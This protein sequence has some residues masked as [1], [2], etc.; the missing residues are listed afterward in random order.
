[1]QQNLDFHT[2]TS[3][4]SQETSEERLR[5][6]NEAIETIKEKYS[7]N[8]NNNERIQNEVEKPKQEK[9]IKEFKLE[10]EKSS[11]KSLK[12]FIFIGLIIFISLIST[13]VY[14]NNF[15]VKKEYSKDGSIID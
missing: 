3:E 11:K 2:K 12:P 13:I 7:T 15:G 5:R 8:H 1:M 9:K 14:K 4:D 6:I 10:Q